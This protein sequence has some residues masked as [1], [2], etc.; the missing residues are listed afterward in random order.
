MAQMK[1]AK[2]GIGFI[3]HLRSKKNGIYYCSRE[4]W[5][6]RNYDSIA[7]ILGKRICTNCKKEY[8]V[9]RG[10]PISG[11]RPF[12]SSSCYHDSKHFSGSSN[13]KGGRRIVKGYVYI[14]TGNSTRRKEHILIAEKALGRNLKK[15]EVVH[16]INLDKTDNRTCNLLICNHAYHAWLHHEMGRRWAIEHLQDMTNG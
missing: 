10:T 12:C 13:W 5:Y 7:P 16:H 3:A 2:C 6:G 9:R 15:G 11:K 4:C 14:C 1:C 8:S